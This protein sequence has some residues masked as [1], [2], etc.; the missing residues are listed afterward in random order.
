MARRVLDPLESHRRVPFIQIRHQGVGFDGP[1]GWFVWAVT[2]TQL[3]FESR[4]GGLTCRSEL[5]SLLLN[6]SY[7]PPNQTNYLALT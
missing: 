4:A 1:R 7:L 6:N 3:H 5:V 2:I